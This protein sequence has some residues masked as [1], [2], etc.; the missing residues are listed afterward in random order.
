MT[1]SN[2]LSPLLLNP[3]TIAKRALV[4]AVIAYVLITLFLLVPGV[5]VSPNW[6]KFWMVRPLIVVPLSGAMGGIFYY[7]ME[8]LVSRQGWKRMVAVIVSLFVYIVGLWLGTVVGLDGTLW[9]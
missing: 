9:N 7:F 6:P 4:G 3:T 5:T 8:V 2:S 1:Q